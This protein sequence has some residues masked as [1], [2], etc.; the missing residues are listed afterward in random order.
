MSVGRNVNF[1]DSLRRC[2]ENFDAAPRAFSLWDRM[3]YLRLPQPLWLRLDPT[4]PLKTLCQHQ[5]TLLAE[6]TVVWGYIVQ[7]NYRLSQVGNDHCP[8]E[9]VYS[10]D[11][12]SDVDH[13]YLGHV[14]ESLGSLKGTTPADPELLRIAEYLTDETIRVFGLAVPASISLVPRCQISTTLFVR[15]HLPNRRLCAPL[16]PV[17]VSPRQPYVVLPL[18][19]RYW[20]EELLAWWMLGGFPYDQAMEEFSDHE[21]VR[22]LEAEFRAAKSDIRTHVE[23]GDVETAALHRNRLVQTVRELEPILERLWHEA[24][25]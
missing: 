1:Q 13:V 17:V 10:L 7:A 8:G 18:P 21:D 4:E 22:R 3:G 12:D 15:K 25:G 11:E 14:A 16:L 20:P 19:A 9:L 6:G 24:H 5:R 2:R 23:R